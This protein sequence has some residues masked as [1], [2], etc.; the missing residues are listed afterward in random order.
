MMNDLPEG[1]EPVSCLE[2]V[3]ECGP[4]CCYSSTKD[5]DRSSPEKKINSFLKQK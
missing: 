4:G 5:E 3:L 1:E 2:V